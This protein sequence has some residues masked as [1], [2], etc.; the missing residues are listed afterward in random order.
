MPLLIIQ[1]PCVKKICLSLCQTYCNSSSTP[2]CDFWF[3]RNFKNQSHIVPIRIFKM[4]QIIAD[5]EFKDACWQCFEILFI[6][7]DC[8]KKIIFEFL[9][10]QKSQSSVDGSLGRNSIL[11]S[12][13]I[14][15]REA[16][17]ISLKQFKIAMELGDPPTVIRCRLY[18]ALSLMQTKRTKEAAHIVRWVYHR[19]QFSFCFR[20]I[21][22]LCLCLK[23]FRR[24]LWSM[25]D[26]LDLC[27]YE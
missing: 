21:C 5:Y 15:A 14:Q 22:L 16:G 1:Y 10:N 19:S 13:I 24:L 6:T 2:A 11:A 23:K 18:Y 7:F 26:H 27:Y 9:A 3:A 20:Q 4:H 17:R 12:C 8:S 25:I